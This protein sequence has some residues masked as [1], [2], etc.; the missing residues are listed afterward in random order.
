MLPSF[1]KRERESKCD[2]K[3]EVLPRD[4]F[5]KE[6]MMLCMF[7]RAPEFTILEGCFDHLCGSFLDL[8]IDHFSKYFSL[9]KMQTNGFWF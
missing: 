3:L 7:P 5:L 1:C 6:I 2:N 4:I 8:W 9:Q